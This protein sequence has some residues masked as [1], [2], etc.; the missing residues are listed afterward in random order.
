MT[1]C[2]SQDAN[3]KTLRAGYDAL[4]AHRYDQAMSAADQ[5]L[6]ANPQKTLPAEAHYLRGRVFEARAM[7][8][9]PAAAATDWQDAR[10]EYIAALGLP[11]AQ[12]LDGRA[13]AGAAN[14]AY[15]QEDYPTAFQQWQEAFPKL[16][17]P[18][19]RALTLYRL[20]QTA[21]HL[22]HW[23]QAD[24]FFAQVQQA[25]PGSDL[26]NRARQHQGARGYLVQLATFANAKQADE[27]A[28]E[29]RKQG[30]VAQPVRDPENS[31]HV[32][33]RVGPFPNYAEAKALKARFAS[34]YPNA[35]IIP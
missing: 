19:D 21:Q 25:A 4:N 34:V 32:L 6:A 24:N 3:V 2:A 35:V 1:G 16:E 7:A 33:L 28:A 12:D 8:A 5:V 17:K 13:R 23:D 29:A 14:V 27:A 22:G 26:A 15:H 30:I 11:H 18:E 10:N 20:G 31:S 9:S